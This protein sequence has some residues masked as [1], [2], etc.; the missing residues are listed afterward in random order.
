MRTAKTDQTGQ[1]PRLKLS[2]RSAN[3]YF[4]L[5]S[6]LNICDSV[7][8]IQYPLKSEMK[9]M[10]TICFHSTFPHICKINTKYHIA[11]P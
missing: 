7:Y 10:H 8:V 2:L 9:S 5:F 1:M 11:S 4:F 3:M 6:V